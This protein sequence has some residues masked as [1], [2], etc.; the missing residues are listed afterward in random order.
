MGV[1]LSKYLH[2][3]EKI[4]LFSSF[5]SKIDKNQNGLFNLAYHDFSTNSN[6][7]V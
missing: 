3:W 2:Y 5:S 7:F 1:I 4:Q 6:Q